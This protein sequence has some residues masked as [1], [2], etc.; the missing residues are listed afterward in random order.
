MYIYICTK[1]LVHITKISHDLIV[2]L[3]YSRI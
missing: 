1:C 3:R 2:T